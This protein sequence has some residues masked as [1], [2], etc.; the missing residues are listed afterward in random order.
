MSAGPPFLLYH[1]PDNRQQLLELSPELSSA[2]IGRRLSCDVPLPWDSE[3][4]RVHAELIRMGADWILCDDGLSH[5]GTFVNGERVRGRRRLSPGDVIKA[6]A[7]LISVC[8]PEQ[9]STA[10]PTRA[11]GRREAL[12]PVTPAQRRLLAILCRPLLADGHA[13]PVS[14]REI[15]DELVISVDTVKGTMSALFELFGLSGLPQNAKRAALA[16]RAL[17]LFAAQR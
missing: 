12:P 14:N 1:D 15:A 16:A 4:S 8:G 13:A 9:A 6:G 10:A 11:A 5:N 7:T 17:D 3:V 2:T